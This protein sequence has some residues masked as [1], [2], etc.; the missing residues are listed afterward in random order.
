MVDEQKKLQTVQ[1]TSPRTVLERTN[2]LRINKDAAQRIIARYLREKM[3]PDEAN[4][5]ANRICDG[6]LTNMPTPSRPA[7]RGY[8]MISEYPPGESR[9]QIAQA[10]LH[11]RRDADEWQVAREGWGIVYAHGQPLPDDIVV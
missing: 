9:D 3:L 11:M 2:D 7:L 10:F 5:L 4:R 6:L 1:I 8:R